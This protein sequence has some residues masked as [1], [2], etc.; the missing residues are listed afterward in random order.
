MSMVDASGDEV[1]PSRAYRFIAGLAVLF[2]RLLRWKVTVVG[3]EHVPRAGGAVLTWNHTSHVDFIMAAWGPRRLKR[4]PRF[5]AKRELWS[6]RLSRTVVHAVGAVPVDRDS[7]E[8]R[9]RSF[10]AAVDALRAGAIVA[11]A[12]EGTISSSFEPLPFRGGAVRMAQDAGVPIVP[13]VTWGSHRLVTY[14]HGFSPRRAWRIPVTVR[15]DEPIHVGPHDDVRAATDR[16]RQ[17]TVELLH[18]VQD[19]YPDG[20]P[21]GAWW[22]PSRLGGGA[23]SPEADQQAPVVEPGPSSDPPFHAL[24]PDES[25]DGPRDADR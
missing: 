12:P 17:V 7:G 18:E 13:C 24:E 4:L 14:G 3:L 10:A 15:Y 9:A 23:P 2:V 11:V 22:V 5:L 1:V 25:D 20:N 6:S 8:G 21:A 19:R 16:L